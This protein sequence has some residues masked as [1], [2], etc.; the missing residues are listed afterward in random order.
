MPEIAVTF[1]AVFSVSNDMTASFAEDSISVNVSFGEFTTIEADP[2]EG[3]YEITP[4]QYT[5]IL[6]SENI[7]LLRYC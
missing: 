6:P 5:Q 4:T 3:A 7:L 1:N 2:Y